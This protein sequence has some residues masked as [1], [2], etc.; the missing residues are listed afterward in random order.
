MKTLFAAIAIIIALIGYIPYV[1]D[2]ISGKTKPHAFSWTIWSVISFIS[3]GIQIANNGGTGS[4]INL[5]IGIL[6]GFIALYG[7]KNGVKNI[8]FLDY[9]A[10]TLSII[11]IILW[12]VV[13]QP[14]ISIVLVILIDF[15]SFIPTITKS[16][17]KPFQE[18]LSTWSLSIV[19]HI[20]AIA[21]L[22][23]LT[24]LTVGYPLYALTINI[25]FCAL[26]LSRR[27]HTSQQQKVVATIIT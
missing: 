25:L 10:L 27:L 16:W 17:N 15:F 18:T 14:Y 9:L 11:A 2:T 1:K 24:F 8:R 13:K 5:I 19:R 21:S 7:I 12:L 23:S 22:T 6:C 20:F 26:L 3:F 4:F